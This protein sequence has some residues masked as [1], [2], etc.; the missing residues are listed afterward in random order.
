M[1][2]LDANR[3][4]KYCG[5]TAQIF[6]VHLHYHG[7]VSRTFS[8]EKIIELL[9]K[10]GVRKALLSSLPNQNSQKLYDLDPSRFY[11]GVMPYTKLS[12]LDWD[13]W[14]DNPK[15]LDMVE[16]LLHRGNYPYVAMG[17]FH[18]TESASVRNPAILRVVEIASLNKL[19]LHAHTSATGIKKLFSV[20]PKIH[21]LWAH[22]GQHNS[23]ND[24][25]P[26]EISRLMDEYPNLW[27]EVA[28]NTHVARNGK[29]NMDWEKLFLR[30]HKRIMVG[31]DPF[32]PARWKDFA[33]I[34][35]ELRTWLCQLP[36]EVAE[37]L[38]WKSAER[39]IEKPRR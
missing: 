11:L 1:R 14:L 23:V 10:M 39:L 25:G 29:L 17:E 8:P 27:T 2:M 32:D 37:D 16:D 21:I 33:G 35:D 31:T 24:P 18:M 9:D 28:F 4:K 22:A 6:D 30:H 26:A 13:R 36:D 3:D 19:F 7:N 15:L 34:V 5:K 12:D 38:A 20:D